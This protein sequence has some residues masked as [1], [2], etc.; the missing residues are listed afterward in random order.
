MVM[1]HLQVSTAS[2]FFWRWFRFRRCTSS[3]IGTPLSDDDT[4]DLNKIYYANQELVIDSTVTVNHPDT[5][6]TLNTLSRSCC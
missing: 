5:G 2:A 3:G 6:I 4:S 1:Q